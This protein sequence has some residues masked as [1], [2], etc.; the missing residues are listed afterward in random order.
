MALAQE[1]DSRL[2]NAIDLHTFSVF[3]R[4][5]HVPVVAGCAGTELLGQRPPRRARSQDPEDPVQNPPI[6]YP[7]HPARL[8]RQQRCDHLLLEFRQLV[9]P[10]IINLPEIGRL[11]AHLVS[12]GHPLYEFVT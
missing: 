10:C 4:L 5:A 6:V 7:S 12:Q 1:Q 3:Q 9:A 11:E 2:I 8:V